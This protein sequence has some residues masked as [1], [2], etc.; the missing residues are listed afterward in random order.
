MV[1]YGREY[2]FH[3][4][5]REW[6]R[7]ECLLTDGDVPEWERGALAANLIFPPELH[8]PI[9]KDTAAFISWF[10]RGGEHRSISDEDAEQEVILETRLPYRFDEDFQLIYAAFL[11]KYGVD[12][13]SIDYLHWW[14][15]RAMFFGLHDCR[16]TDVVGYRTADTSDMSE[17][18]KRQ[19]ETLQAA[20]ELPVSITAQ[21]QIDNA[22]AFLDG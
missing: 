5:F 21:R 11:E 7:Y 13:I 12:L 8:V 9:T 1:L 22:R 14:K 3:S 2:S 18:M 16:F 6:L 10:Y 20:Y 15:F 19:Y 4:D 17:K